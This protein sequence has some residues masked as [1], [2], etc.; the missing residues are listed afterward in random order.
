MKKLLVGL[1]AGGLV[2][3]GILVSLAM[4]RHCPVNPAAYERIEKGMTKAEVEAILGGPPG[5]YRTRPGRETYLPLP[6]LSP[7]EEVWPVERWQGDEGAVHIYFDS[8]GV[9]V[10]EKEFEEAQATDTGLVELI[11]WRLERLKEGLL[12]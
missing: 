4:P 7:E 6:I 9:R 5:D 10:R 1:L 2:L 12:R 8:Y 3:A 11:R